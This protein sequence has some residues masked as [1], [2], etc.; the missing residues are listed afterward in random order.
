MKG[1]VL[2]VMLCSLPCTSFAE[3]LHSEKDY[4]YAWCNR[5]GGDTRCDLPGPERCDC[6]L[7]K[8]AI[9]VDF[10]KRWESAIGQSLRYAMLSGK[11]PGIV[12]ILGSEKDKRYL[13]RL[14]D[15]IHYHGLDITC[16]SILQ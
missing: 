8:Y 5:R 6:L 11:K 12:L 14:R 10:A 7:P 13:S 16:W 9:E 15:T 4:Q 2:L 1:L 3:D